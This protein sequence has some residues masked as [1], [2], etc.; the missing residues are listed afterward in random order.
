MGGRGAASGMSVD[1]HGNPK[2]PYGTEY[3]TIYRSGN[4]KFVVSNSGSAKTPMETMTKGRVY[5]T[6]NDRNE[7]KAVTYYD[8]NNKRAKQID[9]SGN[10]HLIDGKLQLP[11]THLGYV[12]DEH[13]T[14]V[15]TAKEQKMV[16]RVLRTWYYHTGGR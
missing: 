15:L 10:A 3:R 13:G 5:A 14:R 1:K 11:H 8:K 4:I 12:H 7:V 6:V 2:N 9:I 16:E